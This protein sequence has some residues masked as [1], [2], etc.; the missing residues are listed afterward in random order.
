MITNL[1]LVSVGRPNRLLAELPISYSAP[2]ALNDDSMDILKLFRLSDL[3][4]SSTSMAFIRTKVDPLLEQARTLT[5]R[6]DYRTTL[7]TPVPAC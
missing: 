1:V 6:N 2:G 3:Y 5:A 4:M 7:R